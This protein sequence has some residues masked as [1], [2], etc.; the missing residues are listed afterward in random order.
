MARPESSK[1]G[2]AATLTRSASEELNQPRLRFG[3]VCLVTAQSPGGT[4]T[5]LAVSVK[6]VTPAGAA[7]PFEDSGRATPSIKRR[8]RYA[9]GLGA[10]RGT[11][12]QTR[13]AGRK[14]AARRGHQNSEPKAD[15]QLN[16]G[17]AQ[18]IPFR[19]GTR[20]RQLDPLELDRKSVV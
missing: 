12:Y 18:E 15:A 2:E 9:E 17:G 20:V 13:N 3:L 10:G 4:T 11:R 6:G 1:G 14:Q 5:N 7:T 19:D 16:Q 8:T